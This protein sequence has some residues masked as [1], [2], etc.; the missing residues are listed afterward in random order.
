M[1]GPVILKRAPIGPNLDDYDVLSDGAVVGR[2]FL[3]PAAPAASPWMWASGHNGDM[4][5]P[6]TATKRAREAAFAKS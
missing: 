6:R 4:P 5:A 1:I 2:I 3:S